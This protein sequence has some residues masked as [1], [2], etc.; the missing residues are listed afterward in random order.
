LS[1][2]LAKIRT[3]VQDGRIRVSEHG[4]QELT[5]DGISL[6]AIIAGVE[7]AEVVEDYPDHSRGPCV[8]CLQWEDSERP[9]HVLWG[10]AKRTPDVA[11]IITAYRPDPARWTSDLMTRK[12]R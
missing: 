1:D 11:T 10:L 4:M 8:L 6:P 3:C 12:P 5:N 2:T 7:K 9:I